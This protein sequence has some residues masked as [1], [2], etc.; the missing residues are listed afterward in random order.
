MCVWWQ[1][2]HLVQ[3]P[4][5]K[6]HWQTFLKVWKKNFLSMYAL[7]VPF[8]RCPL[9]G[10]TRQRAKKKNSFIFS[11]WKKR[12]FVTDIF[13][14]HLSPNGWRPRRRESHWN[15]DLKLFRAA[16]YKRATLVGKGVQ[17]GET[18]ETLRLKI[19]RKVMIIEQNSRKPFEIY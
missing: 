10:G 18:G 14:H 1:Q 9:N 13:C 4:Q 12:Q 2:S 5:T 19:N 16:N 7:H 6:L 11:R 8:T 3:F 15:V 17:T